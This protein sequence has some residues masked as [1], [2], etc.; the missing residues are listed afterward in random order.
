MKTGADFKNLFPK[1][2]EGFRHAIDDALSGL[3]AERGSRVFPVPRMAIAVMAAL[4]LLTSAAVALTVHRLNIQDFTQRS[5]WANLTDTAKHVLATDFPD[6]AI[7]NRYADMAVTEAV[8]DGMAVYLL[9]EVMPK[10]EAAFVIPSHL[11]E[12]NRA[13]SY[14]SSYP[15]E[16]TVQQYA[17]Q[18]GYHDIMTIQASNAETTGRYFD[19]ARNEDG[20]FSLMIWALVKPE[21]QNIPELTLNMTFFVET[22]GSTTDE[23]TAAFTIPLSGPIETAVSR[24]GESVT[25]EHAGVQIK[26]IRIVRTPMA[27]Y[28]IA[29]YDVVNQTNYRAYFPNRSFRILDENGCEPPKGAYP[30]SLRFDD[31]CYRKDSRPF[32]IT[33]CLFNE[34]PAAIMIGEYAGNREDGWTDGEIYT[35]HLE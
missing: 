16:M 25:F 14:G 22:N 18:L 8:Y 2:D 21:F 9:L 12:N 3:P 10:D 23:L 31:S 29:D 15:T 1:A 20:S 32:Y 11:F 19:S 26:A 17:N 27:A 7:D 30:L 5:P 34:M 28:I 33:N 24:A 4:I 35:F 13:S 6:V